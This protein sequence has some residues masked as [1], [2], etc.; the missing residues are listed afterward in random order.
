MCV[1]LTL[2][3][4][5]KAIAALLVLAYMLATMVS[6]VMFSMCCAALVYACDNTCRQNVVVIWWCMAMCHYKVKCCVNAHV[7]TRRV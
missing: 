2:A 3:S 7:S 5:T 1:S 6:Y 4:A